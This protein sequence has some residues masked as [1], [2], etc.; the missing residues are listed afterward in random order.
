MYAKI[1]LWKKTFISI[2]TVQIEEWVIIIT[3]VFVYVCPSVYLSHVCISVYVYVWSIE[4]TNYWETKRK[5]ENKQQ[6]VYNQ[7]R[8]VDHYF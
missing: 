5:R 4:V 6:N 1:P 7:D 2:R 3:S 8:K